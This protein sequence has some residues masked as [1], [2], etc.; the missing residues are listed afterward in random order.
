MRYNL[1]SK[2]FTFHNYPTTNNELTTLNAQFSKKQCQSQQHATACLLAAC[3]TKAFSAQFVL[4]PCKYFMPAH[5]FFSANLYEQVMTSC[6][7][8]FD[9]RKKWASFQIKL[10]NNQQ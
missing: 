6:I 7:I 8:L 5:L 4:R 9:W 3:F 2:L 10:I 1:Y